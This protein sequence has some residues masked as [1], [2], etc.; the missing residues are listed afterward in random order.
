MNTKTE[1]C[2]AKVKGGMCMNEPVT[3]KAGCCLHVG[4]STGSK[5]PEGRARQIEAN[6]ARWAEIKRALAHYRRNRVDSNGS[7]P[8][9]PQA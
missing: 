3:G 7:T 5:T 4:L 9:S 6:R 1:I 8:R 2:G